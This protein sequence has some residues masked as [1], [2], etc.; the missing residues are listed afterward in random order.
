MEWRLLNSGA[1]LSGRL[2]A[3]VQAVNSINLVSGMLVAANGQRCAGSARPCPWHSLAAPVAGLDPARHVSHQAPVLYGVDDIQS[4]SR[5]LV[6]APA[7]P[8]DTVARHPGTS[9]P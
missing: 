7:S 1:K 9:R 5:A 2:K 8:P 4:V 6:S 3:G